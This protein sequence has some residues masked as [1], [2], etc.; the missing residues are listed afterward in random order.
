MSL[1]DG[2]RRKEERKEIKGREE[3]KKVKSYD[4]ADP[5]ER[6]KGAMSSENHRLIVNKGSSKNTLMPQVSVPKKLSPRSIRI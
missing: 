5:D 2:P 3:R 1:C 6:K 4:L